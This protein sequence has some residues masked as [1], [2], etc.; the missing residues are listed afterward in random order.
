[1]GGK[2]NKFIDNNAILSKLFNNRIVIKFKVILDGIFNQNKF[3]G[4]PTLDRY[5]V[6]EHDLPLT[7]S[8]SWLFDN[9]MTSGVFGGI[10]FIGML[11]SGIKNLVSYYKNSNDNKPEKVLL[12]AFI[13]G[14]LSSGIILYDGSPF[15][16]ESTLTPIYLSGPFMIMV[17]LFS[18]T[19][20]SFKPTNKKEE[21]IKEE[22]TNEEQKITL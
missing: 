22:V 4:F 21:N 11:I 9:F 14:L 20:K 13:A 19:H 5:Y 12:I 6:P 10:A 18:Y 8:G 3:F 16:F 7:F 2:F 15:I 17:F 1:M